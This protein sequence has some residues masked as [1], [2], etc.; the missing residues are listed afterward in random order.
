MGD[1]I[2]IGRILVARLRKYMR[3]KTARN[4][5]IAIPILDLVAWGAPN[6]SSA[7]ATF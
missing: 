4:N 7:A 6:E 3:E 2:A 1:P 5:I